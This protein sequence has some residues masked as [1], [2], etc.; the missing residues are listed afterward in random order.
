MSLSSTWKY[1]SIV[2]SMSVD[3]HPP[4][5]DIY[6]SLNNSWSELFKDDRWHSERVWHDMTCNSWP[7]LWRRQL[8]KVLM[9]KHSPL[10]INC[11]VLNSWQEHVYWQDI[12]FENKKGTLCSLEVTHSMFAYGRIC[13]WITCLPKLAEQL[14]WHGV[15]QHSP[16][17]NM[18]H[19]YSHLF[20]CLH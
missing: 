17:K 19:I 10:W 11:T 9:G 20:P 4:I 7:E 16:C 3:K 5:K 14:S 6:L 13:G 15:I 1:V 8:R 2:S 18:T 12:L